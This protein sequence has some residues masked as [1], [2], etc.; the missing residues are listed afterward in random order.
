[1]T[2]WVEASQASL[3]SVKFCGHRHCGSEYI[4][5][6]VCHVILQDQVT[7][8]S[9]NITGRSPSRLVT[10][11]LHFGGHRHQ[12]QNGFSLSGHFARPRDQRVTVTLWSGAIVR[13][14]P[15]S[16]GGEG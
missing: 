1:M 11:L 16:A 12:R 15:L 3:H 6:L 7:K 14:S 4:M 9:N 10:M 5:A 8:E 2:L 13:I